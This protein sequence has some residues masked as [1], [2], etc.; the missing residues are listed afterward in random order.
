[1]WKPVVIVPADAFKLPPALAAMQPDL[2]AY[3][4][5]W[6]VE[7]W[8]GHLVIEHSG[9][10]FGAVAML[11]LDPRPARGR[12][13]HDQLGGQRRS[14]GRHVP[15]PRPLRR[16]ADHRLDRRARPGAHADGRGRLDGPQS[17]P[18]P[19]RSRRATIGLPSRSRAT[20]GPTKIPGTGPCRCGAATTAVWR[21][22]SS[23]RRAWRAGWIRLAANGFGPCGPTPISR[24]PWWTSTRKG[25][26]VEAVTMRA[27]SPLADFSFD[28]QDLHFA[29]KR[30]VRKA[31]S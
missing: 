9:A 18:P 1:M 22:A 13:G 21:S 23:E 3:G 30:D 7:S 5:G 4:L 27:L 11:Y 19:S 24:T 25:D 2:Q 8:R 16:R 15:H 10:V 20:S 17:R 29:P 31:S 12:V 6:F 14:T 26:G 28:Y